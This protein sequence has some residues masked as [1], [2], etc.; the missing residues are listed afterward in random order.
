[1]NKYFTDNGFLSEEGKKLVEDFNFGLAV[2]FMQEAVKSMS[3]NE[4][5]T[6]GAN[7]GKIIGDLISDT[8]LARVLLKN[9]LD[10]MT[11][12]HFT[13]YMKAKYGKNWMLISIT[14]EEFGRV[15]KMDSMSDAAIDQALKEGA[16]AR[17]QYLKNTPSFHI[18]PGLRFK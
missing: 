12:E 9:E 6:L 7:L 15:K 11:D 10:A 2:T 18:D 5:R 3:E 14:D 16:E 8:L 1:M 13:A 4:L 17:E